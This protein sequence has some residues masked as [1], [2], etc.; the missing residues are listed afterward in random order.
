[1]KKKTESNGDTRMIQLDTITP[2]WVLVRVEQIH[3][4]GL[5]GL[6]AHYKNKYKL[7]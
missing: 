5:D 1:M 3:L 6:K 4:M 7:Q 2:T